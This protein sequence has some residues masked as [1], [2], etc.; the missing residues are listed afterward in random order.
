MVR[1]LR[2]VIAQD[3]I[4]HRHHVGRVWGE[5]VRPHVGGARWGGFDWVSLKMAALARSVQSR[6]YLH[7]CTTRYCLLNRPRLSPVQPGPIHVTT[8]PQTFAMNSFASHSQRSKGRA[9][10]SS[11]HGRVSL[12][13]HPFFQLSPPP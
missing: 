10:A 3:N 11:S 5:M 7:S 2:V 12:N 9:A 1:E 13:R 6:F 4:Y 8:P